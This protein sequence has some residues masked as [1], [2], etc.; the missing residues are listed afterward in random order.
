ML[1]MTSELQVGSKLT[2]VLLVGNIDPKESTHKDG[3][4]VDKRVGDDSKENGPHYMFVAVD[5]RCDEDA[6]K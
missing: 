1:S 4:T 3:A 2:K 6:G 5:A